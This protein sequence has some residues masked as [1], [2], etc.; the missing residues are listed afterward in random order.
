MTHPSATSDTANLLALERLIEEIKDLQSKLI[1]L[2]GSSKKRLLRALAQRLNGQPL[3]VGAGLGRRL[4]VTLLSDR[5]FSTN[6]LLREITVGVADDAP[7]L[8]DN[9]EVL[10]EPSLK[11]NPLNV[12]KL[13]AHSRR[14]I[15]VWP[16]EVGDDRLTYARIGHPEHR[17]YS[18]DGLV[19]FEA[20]QRQ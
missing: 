7:L 20:A 5:S 19:V 6:E 18:R 12:I 9:L 8:L 3:N 2:V 1:L 10:F 14:V 17:D 15:A 11:V 4:A 16:G 13:L